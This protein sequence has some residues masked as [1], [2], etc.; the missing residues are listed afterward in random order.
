MKVDI[1]SDV[2]CPWCY[3]GKRR[4]ELALKDFEHAADVEIRWR[5][6]ELDPGAPAERNGDPTQRIA[7]K[8]GMTRAQAQANEDRLTAMAAEVGL[9]Y[10]LD[11][12]RSGNT[13]DAHR[14]LHLAAEHGRQDA[15]KERLMRGYFTESEPVGDHDTLARLAVEIGLDESRVRAVL[16]SDEYAEAVRADEQQ[17]A[18]YGIS[19]VPFFVVDE[20]YGVSGAQPPEL[21]LE[22]LQKAWAEANPLSMVAAGEGDSGTCEGDSCA[23]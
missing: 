18:A 19:G 12:V 16:A 2:V 9:D 10:H 14:L 13:F 21:L 11:R 1:W 20:R 3:V 23:V 4:F 5:S 15:L 8:Y 7:D 17:A 22:T 6:F